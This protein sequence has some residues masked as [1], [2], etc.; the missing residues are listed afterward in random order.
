MKIKEVIDTFGE[1]RIIDEDSRK[2]Y[3]YSNREGWVEYNAQEVDE[4]G[5]PNRWSWHNYREPG[6]IEDIAERLDTWNNRVMI[7]YALA[8][9]CRASELDPEKEIW[10]KIIEIVEHNPEN[11]F[12]EFGDW[13]P[14]EVINMEEIQESI[15]PRIKKR[16]RIRVE[17]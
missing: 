12:D 6:K 1:K 15:G 9:D 10:K 7:A 5:K 2:I 16:K 4:N 14:S 8:V 13:L 17:D 11:Y 3:D